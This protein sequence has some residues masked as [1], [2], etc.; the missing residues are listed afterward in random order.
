MLISVPNFTH[1]TSLIPGLEEQKCGLLRPF[2]PHAHV[3][4]LRDTKTDIHQPLEMCGN[5]HAVIYQCTA[6][7]NHTLLLLSFTRE[8]LIPV[9]QST[10]YAP[11]DSPQSAVHIPQITAYLLPGEWQPPAVQSIELFRPESTDLARLHQHP[12]LKAGRRHLSFRKPPGSPVDENIKAPTSF[13]LIPWECMRSMLLPCG[14][15]SLRC[16]V[17]TDCIKIDGSVCRLKVCE[18]SSVLTALIAPP[19]HE[20]ESS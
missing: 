8:P 2:L 7:S 17:H 5:T 11:P 13:P 19:K 1:I 4:S 10:P 20:H 3:I 12:D 16:G 6:L 18:A 15:L 14:V 9:D